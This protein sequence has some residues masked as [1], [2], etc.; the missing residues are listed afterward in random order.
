MPTLHGPANS[1]TGGA[2][3]CKTGH[4]C[5]AGFAACTPGLRGLTTSRAAMFV[6]HYGVSFAARSIATQVPL[7][8]WFLAVQWLDVMW[9]ILVLLDVEKLRIVPDFTQANAL[10]LYYMPFTHSLPGSLV[11]SLILGVIVAL[12]SASN[13]MAVALLVAGA[14]FSHWI[15]DFIVHIPDLPLYDNT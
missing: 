3:V 10:D 4:A 8:V 9:S 2:R 12:F 15:L 5:Q 7:W 13:R 1:S 6:G 14:S 11:L